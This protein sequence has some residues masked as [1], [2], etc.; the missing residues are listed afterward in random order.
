MIDITKIGLGTVQFGVN[1]GISNQYGQTTEDE[2][3]QILLI[4]RKSGITIL[5]TAAAYGTSEEV[6]G[7]INSEGFKIVSK[8]ILLNNNPGSLVA[9]TLRNIKRS[10]LYGYL[11]HRPMEIV[12]KEYHWDE[13]IQLKKKGL[14]QKIGFSFNDLNEIAAINAAGIIPDLIQ[15]PFNYFDKRFEQHIKKFK[16]LGTEVHTRSC[17]LQGL[18]FM[19]PHKLHPFFNPLKK[20]I[21]DLQKYGGKLPA[22]LLK[23]CLDKP[24][25]DRVIIGVNKSHQLIQIIKNLKHAENITPL[26][27]EFEENILTPSKWPK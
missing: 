27:S 9:E 3:K 21:T 20:S 22:M 8:F 19:P 5:D 16:N 14:I 13:L 24:Y 4:A 17:F 6:L 7:K 25:I 10:S 26:Q 12:E 18:F 15:V 1:Y 2:A 11:A 23:Y